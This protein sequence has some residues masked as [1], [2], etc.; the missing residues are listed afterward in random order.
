MSDDTNKT[1]GGENE[2]RSRLREIQRELVQ[3]DAEAPPREKPADLNQILN[4]VLSQ[5]QQRK[6]Q[7]KAIKQFFD[8][9]SQFGID[10]DDVPHSSSREEILERHKELTYR[11]RL[12]RSVL[13]VLRREAEK[14]DSK[15]ASDT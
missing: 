3:V 1:D 6:H 5:K 15:T 2:R 7:L 13:S 11:S 14:L 9:P 10:A 12:L 4:E 8:D